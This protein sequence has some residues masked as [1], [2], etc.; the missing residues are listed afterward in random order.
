MEYI[1][2]SVGRGEGR[3]SVEEGKGER[4]SDYKVGR[5]RNVW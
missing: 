1:G 2:E 5:G 4:D 3:E